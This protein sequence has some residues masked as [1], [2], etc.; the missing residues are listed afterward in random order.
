MYERK[1]SYYR[2]AKANNMRSRAAFK[3]DE[4]ARGLIKPGDRVVDLGCW[5]GGWLQ[6]ASRIVGPRGRVVGVDLDEPQILRL[7][8]LRVVVG[9]AFA[10]ET[11]AAI[12]RELEGPADVVLSDMAPKLTGIR[13]TDQA[14]AEELAL[15]AIDV[16][17]ELLRPGGNFVC[18]VFM[19]P[20]YERIVSE[21]RSSFQTTATR[22]PDASRRGSSELYLVAKGFKPRPAE[23]EAL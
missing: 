23:R 10:Q 7:E 18:K 8:N 17:G 2:R 5:P 3:L 9:D 1:D 21:V 16:A 19:G 4:L 15:H 13:D 22:R 11:R 20:S 6:I 14:R 12:R